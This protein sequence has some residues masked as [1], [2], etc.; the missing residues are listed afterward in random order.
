MYHDRLVVGKW[1]SGNMEVQGFFMAGRRFEAGDNPE[2]WSASGVTWM[3]LVEGT[4]KG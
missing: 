3:A 2:G 1:A 4:G